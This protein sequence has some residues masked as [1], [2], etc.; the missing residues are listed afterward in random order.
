MKMISAEQPSDF[1]ERVIE[2]YLSSSQELDSAIFFSPH[3]TIGHRG[4]FVVAALVPL[5]SLSYVDLCFYVVKY[6]AR[7]GY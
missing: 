2:L 3:R 7:S 1:S 5:I 4:E 6:L